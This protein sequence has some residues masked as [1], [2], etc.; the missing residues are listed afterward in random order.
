M[1]AQSNRSECLE[2]RRTMQ[3]ERVAGYGPFVMTNEAEMAQAIRDFQSGRSGSL[4]AG[5]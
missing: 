1:T 4:P 2:A 5:R 3:G